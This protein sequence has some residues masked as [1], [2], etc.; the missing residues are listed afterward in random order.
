MMTFAPKLSLSLSL[1]TLISTAAC[2]H[3]PGLGGSRSTTSTGSTAT[4]FTASGS[5]GASEQ[6]GVD[7]DNPSGKPRMPDELA[8]IY[9][10]ESDNARDG[11]R[12]LRELQRNNMYVS[13][14]ARAV[15]MFGALERF[16]AACVKHKFP[17]YRTGVSSS[18]TTE[19]CAAAATWKSAA[20][21]VFPELA[22]KKLA[23]MLKEDRQTIATLEKSGWINDDAVH[24]FASV[25]AYVASV[26][27]AFQVPITKYGLV[28][29]DKVVAS[30]VDNAKRFQPAMTKAAQAAR[31]PAK[32]ATDG[33][34]KQKAREDFGKDGEVLAAG[35]DDAWTVSKDDA[36]YPEYKWTKVFVLVRPKGASYCEVHTGSVRKPYE[37]HGVYGKHFVHSME[38]D[39]QISRCK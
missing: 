8:A 7:N 9:E 39:Y 11:L 27:G 4:A 5:S 30:L 13:D 29:D 32:L 21:R 10:Q 19:E 23:T 17:T 25:D 16:H 36:D 34:V 26:K 1:A 35:Y 3:V 28:L 38:P 2:I 18:T 12:L 14:I 20:Q 24:R 15:E 37:G 22:T 6:P 31:Y 33:Y